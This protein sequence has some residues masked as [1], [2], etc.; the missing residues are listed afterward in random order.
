MANF[1]NVP[2]RCGRTL[3]AKHNWA[4]ST[5]RCW[6]CRAEVAVPRPRLGG[7]LA[8]ELLG[9][10]R[11]L[12][13]M[14][15]LFGYLLVGALI[16]GLLLVGR[17]GPWLV[18]GVS[19]IAVYVGRHSLAWTAKF[20]REAVRSHPIA[21]A[22]CVLG[23]LPGLALSELAVVGLVREQGWLPYVVLDLSPRSS[24][25][26]VLGHRSDVGIMD[27]SALSDG[28]LFR[29]YA[30]GLRRGRLLLWTIPA[31]LMHRTEERLNSGYGYANPFDW[32]G[33]VDPYVYLLFR[34]G[35][36]VLIGALAL[37]I[38]GLFARWLCL[39]GTV[40]ERY[41]ALAGTD[42]R[43]DPQAHLPT[44]VLAAKPEGS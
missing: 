35:C 29:I 3:R 6:D 20:A 39:I 14:P 23:I 16:A 30:G 41:Q 13:S 24:A 33:S 2:C 28:E 17:S 10:G 15:Q 1:I 4:G 12:L 27:L 40:D 26:A 21:T 9:A 37:L 7:R 32:Q 25:V 34:A 11:Y 8:C 42:H 18:A 38:L 22:A 43:H 44:I 31:S 5:I 19:V 36:T